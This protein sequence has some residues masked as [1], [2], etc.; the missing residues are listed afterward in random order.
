MQLD[1][2][3]LS[4]TDSIGD[5]V[6]VMP[7]AATLKKNFPGVKVAILGQAYTRDIAAT[8]EHIDTFITTD[9]FLNN[10]VLIFGKKPSA[11]IHLTTQ[12]HIASRAARLKIPIRIGTSRR[13]Y[14]LWTCN[15]FVWLNRKNS[16]L[17]EIQLNLA[18][19]KPLGIRKKYSL[20]E[21]A[22]MYGL[23]KYGSLMPRYEQLLE[24]GKYNLVIHPKSQGN[25]R[26]W[27]LTHFIG[28][29]NM[30]NGEHYNIFLSG[31]AKELPFVEEIVKKVN[32]RVHVIAGDISLAQF[33]SFISKADGIVTNSTGPVHI[34]AALGK[35]TIGIYPPLRSKDPGRWGPVGIRAQ[36]F[37]FEKKCTDCIAT[38]DH[39]DCMFK[40]EPAAV[41]ATLDKMAI[42]KK[43]LQQV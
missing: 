39:C 29:I 30:L 43:K 24:H 15:R 25:A 3:I 20:E 19:L 18:L 1:S 13:L 2:I 26:E 6:M 35:D 17:H 38:P 16:G 12:P 34:S 32:K 11:I 40:I 27:P 10:E 23:S 8:C 21:I 5:I 9:E 41:K 7:V 14:H 28:L 42:S 31:V 4:R 36:V 33:I 22:T 37:V